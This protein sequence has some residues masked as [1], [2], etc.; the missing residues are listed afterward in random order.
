MWTIPN[1]LTILRIGSFPVLIWLVLEEK[2]VFAFVLIIAGGITDS[3]DGVIARAFNQQS[4]VGKILDPLADKLLGATIYTSFSL[5]HIIPPWLGALVLS[6]DILMSI[7]AL[8]LLLLGMKVVIKPSYL[9]RRTTGV[10]IGAAALALL[11]VLPYTGPVVKSPGVLEIA[12]ILTGIFTFGSGFQYLGTTLKEY[13][14]KILL[15]EK[16]RMEGSISQ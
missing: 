8:I 4:Q 14:M 1:I 6:R 13:D 11:S 3:L 16:Y 2:Y 10:Q 5:K 12:F 9:G 7:G 15:K